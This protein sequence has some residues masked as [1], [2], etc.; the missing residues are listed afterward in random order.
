MSGPRRLLVDGMNVIGSRPTGWWR[1]RPGAIRDLVESLT[2]Y[3]S[4]SGDRV[5]VVFDGKPMDVV[6]GPVEVMFASRAGPDAADDEI[7]KRVAAD[8][9][10]DGL[11]VITSDGRLAQRVRE[12]GAEVVGAGGF[13]RE[14]DERR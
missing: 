3:A 7:V 14:L 1:D 9:D 10:P 12:H 2:A 4:E 6:A 8:P 11:T 13:R 5:S